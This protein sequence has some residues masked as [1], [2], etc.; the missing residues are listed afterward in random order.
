MSK[1]NAKK[2]TFFF[3]A[4]LILGICIWLPLPESVLSAGGGQLLPN[5]R[6]ALGVLLFCLICWVTE[7]LPFHITGC[8]GI[9]FLAILKVDTFSNIISAGFGSDT[10]V[11]FIGSMIISSGITLSGLGK[12]VSMFVLSRIGNRTHLVVLAFLLVGMF[13]SAWVTTLAGAVIMTPLGISILEQEGVEKGKSNFGKALMIACAWGPLCGGMAAPT[14]SG[15]NPIAINFI[16]ET[17]GI[18]ITFIQWMIFGLPC[19]FVLTLISWL[20][21]IL[22]FRPEFNRLRQS[23]E[24][25]QAEYQALKPMDRTE[26]AVGCI[27]CLTVLLWIS[28]SFLGETLNMKIPTSMPAVFGTCLMF[29]PG[30]TN[31]KWNRI[32]KQIP[33]SNVLLIATGLCIGIEFYMTGAAEWLSCLLFREIVCLSPIVRIFCIICVISILKLG[34]SSNTVTATVILPIIIALT[35]QAQLPIMGV[36]I[37][38]CMAMSFA[39]I[40]VTSTPTNVI[41]YATGWFKI[42]DMAKAGVF[43]TL[44]NAVV[45]TFLVFGIGHIT[46][47]YG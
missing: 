27:F 23:K 42:S 47:I 40:A 18:E 34:L 17:C 32:E 1:T 5:G 46:G 13:L 37:P 3:I 30:M 24:E 14:G 7:S 44:I 19:A 39:F 26:K 10:I 35:V 31:L 2:I 20:V 41:P 12:R 45:M 28:S 8:M 43:N 38:G 16:S 11:F 22:F 36:L 33:W 21:L 4:L 29:L 15:C 25:L 9:L 6:V